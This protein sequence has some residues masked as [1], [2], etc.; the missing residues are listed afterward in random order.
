M[1]VFAPFFEELLFRG[2]VFRN[3]ERIG[4]L[5]AIVLTGI[6][7]GLWHVNSAQFFYTA[8]SGMVL[9]LVFLKTRSI[10]PCILF[11][12]INNLIGYLSSMCERAIASIVFVIIEIVKYFKKR[13]TNGLKSG[14]FNIG[15]VKKTL[16]YFSSPVTMIA[17]LLLIFFTF[18]SYD[19]FW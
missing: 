4:Q 8:V 12:L 13:K 5:F 16:Y 18:T 15:K 3:S 2:I 7:F 19:V 10:I 11:H 9:A 17:Y 14:D 1:V 6:S